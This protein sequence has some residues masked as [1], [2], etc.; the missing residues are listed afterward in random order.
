MRLCELFEEAGQRKV[1]CVFPGG[2]HIFTRGHFS[3]Y[4][5]LLKNFPMADV[6][7]AS[8]NNTD[9]RPFEFKDKQFLATQAG[10]P[11]NKFVEVVSP[12]KA[13]EITQN[14]NPKD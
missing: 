11:S 6:F 4:N 13:N 12:Y 10:V 3:V 1:L 14:Y 8:S 9:E 5:Y 7:V 2:F